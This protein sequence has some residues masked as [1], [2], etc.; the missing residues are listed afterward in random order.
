MSHLFEFNGLKRTGKYELVVNSTKPIM[1]DRR[2]EASVSIRIDSV[3]S[4][5]NFITAIVPFSKS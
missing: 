4:M 1:I 2:H 3:E 5:E